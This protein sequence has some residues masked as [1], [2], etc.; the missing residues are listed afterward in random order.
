MEGLSVGDRLLFASSVPRW[1]GRPFRCL[2]AG[3][4]H[5]LREA[6]P[7]D[8][9]SFGGGTITASF[10]T[11]ADSFHPCTATAPLARSGNL[12]VLE[13]LYESNPTSYE[14]FPA[15]ADGFPRFQDDGTCT[16]RI[17]D[18]ARFSTGAA[19]TAADVVESYERFAT[20]NPTL[21]QHLDFI[22]DMQATDD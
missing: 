11:T 18:D 16:I 9:R 17:R 15:L 19:V 13:P 8:T 12:H 3:R 10:A 7:Q 4:P 1:I 2:R 6:E 20:L 14:V 5:R 21:A 22:A